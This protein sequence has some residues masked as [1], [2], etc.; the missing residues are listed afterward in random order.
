MTNEPRR[1]RFPRHH[2]LSGGRAFKAVYAAK[3]R[4]HVGGRRL[5]VVS[6]PNG[7]G[8][9]RLGLSVSRKVGKAVTRSRHKRRLREAFR[10]SHADWLDA[11]G[12]VG[13]DLVIVVKRHD[14]AGLASYRAWLDEAAAAAH[15][16]WGKRERHAARAE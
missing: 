15:A 12:G 13:Y 7:L 6:R 4:K 9:F 2:R 16:A 1:H 10:L 14:D 8:H 11:N 3:M 5:T